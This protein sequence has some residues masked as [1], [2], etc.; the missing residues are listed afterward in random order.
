MWGLILVPVFYLLSLYLLV[1]YGNAP[2]NFSAADFVV[3]CGFV[4]AAF[5]AI[6]LALYGDF[7]REW[8]FPIDVSIEIPQGNVAFDKARAADGQ[9]VDTYCHHLLVRNL[10]PHRAVKDC[11][12]WLKSVSVK[13]TRGEWEPKNQTP[14]PRL[15][16]WAPSEYSRDK[17]TFATWQV[18]DFG[19]TISNNGGFE[20]CIERDQHGAFPRKFSVGDKLRFFFFVTADN[21]QMEKEFSFDVDVMPSVPGQTVT[22]ATITQV[23]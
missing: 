1:A 22:P 15:M 17:R 12:V 13:N 6:I 8:V 2:D 3:K 16:E 18:F 19:R 14:V 20:L 4:V 9:I 10:T 11:R 7:F 21:Y 23:K 5:V